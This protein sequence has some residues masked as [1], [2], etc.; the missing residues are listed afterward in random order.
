MLSNMQNVYGIR[1]MCIIVNSISGHTDKCFAASV[2]HT[3]Y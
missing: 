3:F 1:K 2:F